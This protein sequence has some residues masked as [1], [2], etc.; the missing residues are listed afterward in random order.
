MKSDLGRTAPVGTAAIGHGG[1]EL[2]VNE[3]C[4]PR[5]RLELSVPLN[6]RLARTERRKINADALADPP[7]TADGVNKNGRAALPITADGVLRHLERAMN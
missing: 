1:I 3:T 4:A 6:K 5:H 7:R 2:A